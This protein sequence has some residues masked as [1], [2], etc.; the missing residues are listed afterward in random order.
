MIYLDMKTI[1]LRRLYWT[2]GSKCCIAVLVFIILHADFIS[3]KTVG[4]LYT[5][6]GLLE[7]HS[8]LTGQILCLRYFLPVFLKSFSRKDENARQ[9]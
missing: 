7:K 6:F 9:K 5:C 4:W 2:D 1:T 8:V 3:C